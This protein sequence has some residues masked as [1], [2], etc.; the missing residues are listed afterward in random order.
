M[1]KKLL[2]FK[3]KCIVLLLLL[4]T[5]FAYSGD[6]RSMNVSNEYSNEGI[7]SFTSGNSVVASDILLNNQLAFSAQSSNTAMLESRRPHNLYLKS[8]AIGWALLVP[9]IAVEIDLARQW[10][11]TLPIYYSA[12]NYFKSTIKFRTFS[13]QPELRYW[14]VDEGQIGWFV[15]AHLGVSYYNFAWDGKFRYQDHKAR[16][17]A[18][19][20]GIGGGYRV[21]LTQ[22]QRWNVEFALGVGVYSIHYDV[23]RN[24]PNGAFVETVKKA[25]FG[26]DNASVAFSYTFD[27]K[28]K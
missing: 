16:R 22:D 4:V 1:F 3:R 27:L 28:K 17:P 18:F 11:L 19:G 10:S 12:L 25:Y 23:F 26:L 6:Y 15:G 2:D 9:N 13:V 21:P 14:F 24:E 8:N 20:G 7:T 5:N